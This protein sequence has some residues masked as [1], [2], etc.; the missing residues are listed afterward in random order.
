MMNMRIKISTKL[1]IGFMLVVLLM[2]AL[3]L[4]S[5]DRSQK[6]LQESVGE[7]S[8]SLAEAVLERIDNSIYFRIEHLRARSH[9]LWLQKTVSESNQEFE[10]LDDIQE[11]I[12]EKDKK[13]TSAPKEEITPFM[14]ELIGN[15]L[16]NNLRKEFIELYEK[17]YGYRIFGEVFVTNKYGA[18]IAQTGKTSDYR[19]DDEEWWQIAKERGLYV[20]DVE[21][22]ESAGIYSI[23]IGIR[24]DDEEGNFI[25]VIKAVVDVT[26]LM[27]EAV[28]ATKKY[29][30]TE[31]ELITKEGKLVYAT[32]AYKFLED[33][34]EKEFFE[35]IKGESGF[36]VAEEGG[37]EKLFS[38]A[39]SKGYRDFE[40]LKWMLVVRYDAEEVLKPVFTL[41]NRIVGAS[42]VLITMSILIAFFISRSI[43]KPITKLRDATIEIAR[44]NLDTRVEVK[45][46]DEIGELATSFKKMTEDL[47]RTTVSRDY[48]RGLIE[49]NLD[50]LVMLSAEGKIADVN[51]AMELIT[52]LS[53][54]EL[55]GTDF[56]NYFTD[57][58]AARKGYQ[59]VLRDGYVR[60]YPLEI[61]HRDEIVTPVLYNASV[62]K[63]AQG[64]IAGVFAAARDVTERKKAEE[65]IEHLNLV[66]RAI[67]NVNQLIAKEKDRDRL[68]KD[69]C[70][71]LVKARGYYNAWLALIDESGKLVTTAEAG[72]GEDF[73]PMVEWL[74]RGE[75]TACGQKTLKQSGVVVTKDPSSTCVDCP[76]AKSYVGRG[77]MTVRLEHGGKMYGFL[78]ASIPAEFT[79]D[80][81]EQALFKELAGDVAFALRDIELE[82]ARKRAEKALQEA[83]EKA[84]RANQMKSI[85]LASMSHELRTPLNSII[86]FT[87]ILLQ[88]LAGEL[89][90][91]QKKQLKMVYGSSK[92]LLALINDLLDISKIESGEL[93]PELEEFNLA[94]AG[95]EVRDSLMPK[96]E[97]KAL[98]LIWDIPGITVVSDERRFKQ[99]LV[100]LVNN[101]IKFTQAGVVEVKAIEKEKNIEVIV[102]DTGIGIKEEDLHKLF[103]PFTQLEYT[104]S[105]EKGTGLGLY[106]VRNL[107]RL[108]N[109]DIQVESEYGKGSIFTFTLPIKYEK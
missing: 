88:G 50:A 99:I 16:S 65:R 103:A 64:R 32:K 40:G 39:H 13:W 4:Y 2:V 24:V 55:I 101:A 105:E 67:R 109:G 5:V 7:S 8:I 18:N 57:P 19:Q 63:D 104:V 23:S 82:E 34:S 33:V 76:L 86:G 27:K 62:Y 83:K 26:G 48:T 49:V 71:A 107:A 74:K 6:S 47:Q 90:E 85:F 38:Y 35:D 42:L 29:E 94:D 108:L 59:Q 30:T 58:D 92:H 87:G 43:S 3:A 52:G 98:K 28:I 73:L 10:K 77:A 96:A 9:G 61:K 54:K 79:A 91:E 21:Y 68:L 89:N 51:R 45:S 102:K 12:N 44:G 15:E 72:L 106:L 66:L 97:D 25:G 84:E 36:F 78:S 11:Y 31:I 60:D 75:L 46:K 81:E 70:H 37:R 1:I 41:R 14:Q 20:G 93:E 17:K 100:N 53:S 69:G 22:D 80:E 56:S 95:I